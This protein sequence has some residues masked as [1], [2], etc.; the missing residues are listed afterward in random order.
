MLCIAAL[1]VST[2]FAG[3]EGWMRNF[4]GARK[5]ASEEKKD[6]LVDFT[7][8]DWCV[9]CIRLNKEV[10]D[11]AEFKDGVKEGF[12]LVE[13]DYP[14]DKSKISEEEKKQNEELIKTY[15]IKG[16]PTILLCDPEGKPFAS[17]G[18]RPDGPVPY[19]KHLGELKAKRAAR[20][21]AFAKAEAA[22]GVEKAKGYVEAL[23]ALE[24]EDGMMIS[25]YPEVVA[26]IKE[27]DPKDETGFAKKASDL[28]RMSKFMQ[29]FGAFQQK[30]D[31][32]GAMA[33]LDATLADKELG[34][35]MK[36]HVHGHKAAM[37]LRKKDFATA[38]K[39]LEDGIAVA[40]DSEVAKQLKQFVAMVGKM[41][42]KEKEKA[43]KP[44]TGGAEDAK[45]DGKEAPKPEP[46]KAGDEAPKP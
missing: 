12:V 32:E 14:N 35:D 9:W 43:A 16:Y 25:T 46:A 3:G 6:L 24:L 44:E 5:K 38:V 27:A 20:D 34:P 42:E 2:V 37:Y 1:S 17:T 45:K 19:V 39:V 30:Q 40:P 8:S 36:Q 4:E 33:F 18:Y 10:F 23:K 26:K 11:H 13:L 7:G 31:M 29:E 41:E 22:S 21:E 28:A 15:P